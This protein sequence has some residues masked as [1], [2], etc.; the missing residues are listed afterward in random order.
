MNT[1]RILALVLCALICFTSVYADSLN[2]S[3]DPETELINIEGSFDDVSKSSMYSIEVKKVLDD[4]VVY[5]S[6]ENVNSKNFKTK[7]ML[8]SDC[9]PEEYYVSVMPYS[10]A[11][12]NSKDK[13]I[14]VS[15][16][17]KKDDILK[18]VLSNQTDKEVM[19][20]LLTDNLKY[21]GLTK[22][23]C[24]YFS[25]GKSDKEKCANL[26]LNKSFSY[27]KYSEFYELLNLSLGIR[28]LDGATKDT[29]TDIFE[30]YAKYFDIEELVCYPVYS[31]SDKNIKNQADVKKMAIEN[32]ANNDLSDLDKVK[33]YFN[34]NLLLAAISN[35]VSYG[36]IATHID[37]YEDA[38]PFSL[39]VY[40]ATNKTLTA[41]YIASLNKKYS[42]MDTLEDDILAA[43]TSQTSGGSGGSG[44]G[45]GSSS[46]GGST[47][48]FAPGATG[49]VGLNDTSLSFNDLPKTH[50]AY[51][52]VENLKQKGIVSGDNN[53]NFNP[54]SY[55]T[56]E[57]FAKMLVSALGFYDENA[58]CGFEDVINH[59]S[60]KYVA[61]LYNKK[62]TSGINE[63]S[64]G[65][66]I[67]ITREDMATL[68]AKAKNLVSE[69]TL[70]EFNDADSIS[71]YA[72]SS[73]IALCKFG[74]VKGFEDN[75]FRPKNNATR[76]EAASIIYNLIK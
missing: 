66:G 24:D 2:V 58:E 39:S 61:S 35:V 60:Y 44:G 53:G 28:M 56:R 47:G 18:N 12:A 17:T 75:S 45:G 36:E 49:N 43:Y 11:G 57:E 10:G 46:K 30:K 31:G 20:K 40:N 15:S 23:N 1:K 76:A 21:L 13:P 48:F 34:E 8:S 70:C 63:T 71:D 42:N 62:I 64:F 55:I 16:S 37:K 29:A 27:E 52:I 33:K 74:A 72:L 68:C 7:V 69:D 32:F 6:I 59:W 4:S 5:T 3:Y 22:D 73:V 67:N 25:L 26:L 14:F 54:D 19:A 51:N 41:Q 38:I 65:K 9:E 50:W